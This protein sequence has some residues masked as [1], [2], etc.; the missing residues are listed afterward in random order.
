MATGTTT[1]A[2]LGE[3]KNT[4]VASARIIK[5]QKKGMVGLVDRVTLDE[6]SGDTWYETYLNALTATAVTELTDLAKNPQQLDDGDISIEPEIVGIYTLVT[7]KAKRRLSKLVIAKIGVLAQNAIERKKDIDALAMISAAT[8]TFG[9]AGTTMTTGLIS[10]AVTRILSN[11]TEIGDTPVY[12]VMHGNQIHPIH[13]ELVAGV[14]TRILTPGLTQETFTSYGYKGMVNGA[15]V[16]EN[17][18]VSIDSSNDAYC[19][20]FAKMGIVLVQETSPRV[21]TEF[22]PNLGG[23]SDGVYHY[24]YYAFGERS[25][26]HWLAYVLTDASNPSS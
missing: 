16:I 4:I 2:S 13:N 6:G 24:D 22:K 1:V 9:S 23:G 12:A 26:G 11:T 3:S 14:G 8:L 17:G 5:E 25:V 15:E 10:A 7:Q 19:G 21:Y 20:V 18:N